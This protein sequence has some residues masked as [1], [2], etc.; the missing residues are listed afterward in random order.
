MSSKLT[1]STSPVGIK[2][3]SKLIQCKEVEITKNKKTK[4]GFSDQKG[5]KSSSSRLLKAFI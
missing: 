5:P 3:D 4:V 1:T 2:K